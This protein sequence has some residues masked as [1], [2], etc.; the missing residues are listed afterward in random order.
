MKRPKLRRIIAVLLMLAGAGGLFTVFW[1]LPWMLRSYDWHW[2]RR[3]SEQAT[4]EHTQDY[5]HRF[6]WRHDDFSPVGAYGDRQWAE[7]IMERMLEEGPQSD[8]GAGHKDSAFEQITNFSPYLDDSLPLKPWKEEL[9]LWLAWWEKNKHKTQ[10]EWMVDG[11]AAV[12]VTIHN[13]P[14]KEDWPALLK[15]LGYENPRFVNGEQEPGRRQPK[16]LYQ[17]AYRCLRDSDFNPVKFAIEEEITPELKAGLLY[18]TSLPFLLVFRPP[19]F[20]FGRRGVSIP[21]SFAGAGAGE[22]FCR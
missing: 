11:F 18:S 21:S 19:A 8:C 9:P 13:P 22:V 16:F 4:W 2:L 5:V 20:V 12:G 10:E 6:G 7:W 3:H 1:M 17:N 14:V 15:L